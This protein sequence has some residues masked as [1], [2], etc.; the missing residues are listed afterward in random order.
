[1]ETKRYKP[2]RWRHASLIRMLGAPESARRIIMRAGYEAP[3]PAGVTM[4]RR[5]QTIGA[6]WVPT[7]VLALIADGK[8]DSFESALRMPLK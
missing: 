4:W 1:M 7:V 2:P 8:L 3:T 5:R 6:D